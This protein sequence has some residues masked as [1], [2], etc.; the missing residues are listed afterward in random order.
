LLAG[1]NMSYRKFFEKISQVQ[2]KRKI[3]VKLPNFI[4]NIKQLF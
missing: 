2:E 3:Y 4:L 1:S